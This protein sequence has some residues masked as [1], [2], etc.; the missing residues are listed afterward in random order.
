MQAT[1]IDASISGLM[2]FKTALL[3]LYEGMSKYNTKEYMWHIVSKDSPRHCPRA[4]P[5]ELAAIFTLYFP[6][7]SAPHMAKG[8]Q[9]NA[10]P[11]HP[12][13]R[14]NALMLVT[15]IIWGGAFVA[16][17]IGMDDIGPFLFSGLR[18]ILGAAVV[19]PF[20]LYRRQQGRV[21]SNFLDRHLWLAGLLLGTLVAIGINLQQVGLLYTQVSHAGFIT[22]MYVIFV[23]VL[24]LLWGLNTHAST[25]VGASLALLGLSLLSVSEQLSVAPGDW[26]QL[27]SALFWAL[28]VLA[29][30]YFA[31]R[32]DP[33]RLAFIQ[34]VVCAA[35]SLAVSI[36]LE[37]I[38]WAS[39]RAA[40]PA[41]L[42]A[43]L[44]STGI[45]F[46]LQAIALKEANPAHA[47]IILSLEGVFAA[48]AAMLL[49]GES[50]SARGYLGASLMLAA[51]LVTQLWRRQ[52]RP[53]E[54]TG[55]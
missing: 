35:L 14:T 42:Y 3:T 18:F 25:W 20:L 38:D 31:R 41:L 19:L 1:L 22:G 50:L 13:L 10:M 34:F 54:L 47:A 9:F 36:G 6:C 53:L 26:L 45:G 24:G 5:Y 52:P 11:A 44:L 17:R 4:M 43:G 27:L 23:P 51:I 46:S 33:L 37:T 48:L 16:Q 21:R 7:R 49:L 30:G 8:T 55:H 12:T 28:H 32:H 29:M 39:I 15:A 40:G 2:C